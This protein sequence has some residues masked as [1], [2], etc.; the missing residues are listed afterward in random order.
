MSLERRQLERKPESADEAVVVALDGDGRV[1]VEAVK[2]A[3]APSEA[4]DQRYSD[5]AV[6]FDPVTAGTRQT[7]PQRNTGAEMNTVEGRCV[8]LEA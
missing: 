6:V 5:R 4:V 8:P 2:Q 1:G 3:E 7:G